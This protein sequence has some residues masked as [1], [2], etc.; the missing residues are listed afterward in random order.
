MFLLLV[1]YVNGNNARGLLS[2]YWRK[3]KEMR[4]IIFTGLKLKEHFFLANLSEVELVLIERLQDLI[5]TEL[6]RPLLEVPAFI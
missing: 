1:T 2:V 3:R 6:S 4:F 5:N